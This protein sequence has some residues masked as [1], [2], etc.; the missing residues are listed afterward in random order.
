VT[1]ERPEA[2]ARRLGL[3]LTLIVAERSDDVETAL[4]RIAEDRPV[5]IPSP[6]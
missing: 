1:R 2:E 4:A 3:S 5:T 6:V